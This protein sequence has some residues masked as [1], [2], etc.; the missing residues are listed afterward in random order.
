[1]VG[2]GGVGGGGGGG[3]GPSGLPSREGKSPG[4]EVEANSLLVI[5]YH[6]GPQLHMIRVLPE[7]CLEF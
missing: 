1:M 6:D 7:R 3:R 5:N 2:G 4:N